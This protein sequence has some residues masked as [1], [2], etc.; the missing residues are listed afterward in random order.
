MAKTLVIKGA[1]FSKNK[2]TTVEFANIPC[3]GIGF[4]ESTYMLTGY[5]PVEIEYTVT[6]SDT[7]DTVEWESSDQSVALV[8]N[9]DVTAVG[10][11]TCTITAT[12]GSYSASATITVDLAYISS[13]KFGYVGAQT[14]Y[15][16]NND[17]KN[18]IGCYGSGNQAGEYK[19]LA[20]SGGTN[21]PVI[22]LPKNTASVT[23]KI[24]GT[25]TLLYNGGNCAIRWMKDESC[26]EAGMT[27]GALL[28]QSESEYNARTTKES[29][30][31]VPNNVDSMLVGLRMATTYS[32]ED[33][34]STI[35]G[36]LGFALTFNSTATE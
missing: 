16:T 12:C 3:T 2:L 24:Q 35:M 20:S 31:N 19:C 36:T 7:T 23:I 8:S 1:D 14:K 13:Y 10:L 29:T 9:G 22:K 27:A 18:R 4:E 21:M 28:V 26:G 15:T 25:E 17:V 11:G 34:A 33:S 32:D 5:D 30:F 6:P